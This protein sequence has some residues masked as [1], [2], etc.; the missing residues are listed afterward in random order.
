MKTEKSPKQNCNKFETREE[1][2]MNEWE[3]L[4][5]RCPSDF[6][7]VSDG[8]KT[9]QR[10]RR[11]M[12]CVHFKEWNEMDA[13]RKK[14]MQFSSKIDVNVTHSAR[15]R[16]IKR[17]NDS[18]PLTQCVPCVC[19][20]KIPSRIRERIYRA[21][22]CVYLD[23]TCDMRANV[24]VCDVWTVGL[25]TMSTNL[26]VG[27]Y[28]YLTQWCRIRAASGARARCRQTYWHIYVSIT[29]IHLF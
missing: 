1:I 9:L 15:E 7:S 29:S 6:D 11:E 18:E 12:K 23:A 10:R 21:F 19:A 4:G 17:A 22:D 26:G 5:S 20:P 28:K 8:T 13:R 16:E 25:R 3:S 2:K 27:I 24:C 14:R